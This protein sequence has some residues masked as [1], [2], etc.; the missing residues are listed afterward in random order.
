MKTL[1]VIN[2][3]G[4]KISDIKL[5]QKLFDGSVN[6]PLVHEAALM[7]Q[8]NVRAGSANTKARAEV[9]GGGRKPW[10]QKGTGRARAGSIRSPLWRGGGVTFGPKPRD[11]YRRLPKKALKEALRSALND[12]INENK[13]II[14]DKI[15]L[16]SHK[17]KGFA[18]ILK[19]LKLDFDKEKLLLVV[20][21][22]NEKLKKA[23]NNLKKVAV[24]RGCDINAYRVILAETILI[25]R[26][27]FINLEKRLTK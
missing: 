20:D 14:L 24:L 13:I 10:R 6:Q 27:A 12:K 7:Y 9:R 11:Y 17:T 3:E 8:A 25:Q 15:E 23:S 5:N 22:V 16:A 19:K 1:N 26:T 21:S 2:Q 4:K 18:D